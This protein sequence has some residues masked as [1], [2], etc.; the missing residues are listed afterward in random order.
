MHSDVSAFYHVTVLFILAIWGFSLKR[1]SIITLLFMIPVLGETVQFFIPS[2]T[3]DILDVLHGYL[4]ILAG[5]CL[6]KMWI[7]IQ[8]VVKNIQFHLERQVLK[9]H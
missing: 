2:R 3:V 4:G 5:Y 6:V 8:P 9:R 1:T 7:E